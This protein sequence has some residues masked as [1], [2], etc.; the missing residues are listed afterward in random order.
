MTRAFTPDT[1]KVSPITAA[2]LPEVGQFLHEN[3]NRRFTAERWI[4][5]L[6]HPW[7]TQ[8]PNHGMLLRDADRLVG[9]FCAIYSEQV[10]G[11]RSERFCNPHSWCVLEEYR[12]HGLSLILQIIRQRDFHFTMF[13]P[14]PKVAEVFRGLKFKDLD[15]RL[16]IYPNL[17]SPALALPGRFVESR[18]D[19]VADHLTGQALADYK[20]HRDIPWLNFVAFGSNTDSCFVIYKP[21]IW[22]RARCAWVMHLSDSG[23][24]DRHGALLRTHLLLSHGFATTRVEARWLPEARRLAFRS[25]RTQSKLYQSKT[26]ADKDI[27]DVYSELM[28]L[29]V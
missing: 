7:A 21:T 5:S 6:V 22:K 24:F 9:V 1:P 16:L 19:H 3:L 13:T 20:A 11:G 14:N 10:I 15:P 23:A 26:L 25:L 12:R 17:P 28:S 29:D 8:A 4:E 18:R 27:R 2:D